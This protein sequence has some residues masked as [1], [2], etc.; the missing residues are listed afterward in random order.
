M[1]TTVWRVLPTMK[2]KR[3]LS[4][5]PKIHHR[6]Q[7]SVWWWCFSTVD[8]YPSESKKS[9][10]NTHDRGN[11]FFN[12]NRFLLAPLNHP[13]SERNFWWVATFYAQKKFLLPLHSKCFMNFYSSAFCPLHLLR[14]CPSCQPYR[15][16]SI[17][18]LLTMMLATN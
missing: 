4:S 12:E 1:L 3:K 6:A 7:L 11:K 17:S 2:N 10:S 13:S 14:I 16:S 8:T 5:L 9:N 15:P 18:K